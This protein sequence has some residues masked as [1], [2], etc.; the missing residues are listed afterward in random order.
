MVAFL[1]VS[2]LHNNDRI[3]VFLLAGCNV[4]LHAF[5]I[6]VSVCCDGLVNFVV[7]ELAS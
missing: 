4:R 1:R 5:Q 2:V 3:R 7:S 6:G